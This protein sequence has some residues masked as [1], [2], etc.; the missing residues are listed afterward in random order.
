MNAGFCVRFH[1]IRC[2][3]TSSC[4]SSFCLSCARIRLENWLQKIE[5]M[6]FED[7][8]YRHVV[9]TIPETLRIYFYREPKKLSR[10]IKTGL[11]MLKEMIREVTKKKIECGYIV[12]L[13][14]A[15]RSGTYNPHLHIMMTTGGLDDKGKWH[16]IKYIPFTLV[17]KKWQYYLFEMMKEE[18]GEEI[19][20]LID[21]L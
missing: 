8:D 16:D 14:T 4:K 2:R 15:G 7:V 3:V 6:L 13:Q 1:T 11:E 19:K 18:F 12:V 20:P 17:H 9:L 10:F 5:E 21:R